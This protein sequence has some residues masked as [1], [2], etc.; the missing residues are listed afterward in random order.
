MKVRKKISLLFTLAVGLLIILLPQTALAYDPVVTIGVPYEARVTN[1]LHGT[2]GTAYDFKDYGGSQVIFRSSLT[3]GWKV[4]GIVDQVNVIPLYNSNG[5][6]SHNEKN[7]YV[8]VQVALNGTESW[9]NMARILYCHLDDGS[10]LNQGAIIF[11]GAVIGRN[12]T[13]HIGPG[14]WYNSSGRLITTAAHLHLELMSRKAR[15]RFFCF[16]AT[17][18]PS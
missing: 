15:G 7:V 11:P 8:Q 9:L 18:Q 1:G 12:S 2:T 13:S 10:A 5:N 16:P 6:F 4:R 14:H 3:H 17:Q